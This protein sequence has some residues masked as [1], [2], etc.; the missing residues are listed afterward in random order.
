[1]NEYISLAELKVGEWGLVKRL[2]NESGMK[3]RLLDVGLT[4]NS[5]VQCVAVSPMGDPKAYL[6]CGAVMAIRK[7]DGVGVLV[8]RSKGGEG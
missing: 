5:F 3:K 8:S 6:L 1:M 2:D 4:E 7:V